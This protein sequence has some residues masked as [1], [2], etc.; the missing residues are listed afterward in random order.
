MP[1]PSSSRHAFKRTPRP[2][3]WQGVEAGLK[4]CSRLLQQRELSSAGDMAR[5]VLEFAPMEGRA[6]HLLGRILQQTNRHAEALECFANA[7][8]CYGQHQQTQGPPAS[9]RLARLLWDQGEHD[10]AC[11]MMSI[12]MIRNP[13]DD[14]LRQ[15]REAWSQQ[16]GQNS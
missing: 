9:I 15:L 14:S 1:K 2:Q 4:E 12:L 16:D 11:A 3:H 7:E 6:W 5:Q 8:H 10:E 13:D